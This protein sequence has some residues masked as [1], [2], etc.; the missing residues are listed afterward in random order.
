MRIIDSISRIGRERLSI[1]AF[2]AVMGFVCAA[3]VSSIPDLKAMLQFNDAQLGSLLLSG[4]VGT[5]TSYLFVGFLITRLGSCRTTFIGACG[6]VAA[7]FLLSVGF[8]IKAPAVFWCATLAAMGAFG[9]L[10]NTS[11]NTQGGLAELRAGHSIMSSFHAIWSVTNLSGM[12]FAQIVS[13]IAL[14]VHFRIG[15]I[16]AVACVCVFAGRPGLIPSDARAGESA[17]GKGGWRW[18]DRSLLYL[19]LMAMVFM[20]CEG[21]IYDWVGVFYKDALSAPPERV[22][23]GSC[24]VMGAMTVGRFMTDGLINRYTATRIIHAYSLLVFTGLSIALSSP[25]TGLAGTGLHVVATVGYAVAGF[26]IS[27]LVPIVYAKTARTK[28]MAPGAAVTVVSSLGFL[29]FFFAPPLIG[30]VSNRYGLSV[31]LSIFAFLILLGLF[32]HPDRQDG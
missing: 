19:G 3:W 8:A 2:F 22:L 5:A 17:S 21:S 32:M 15:C 23:W 7:T 10:L 25:Y 30:S 27:G 26:G 16:A 14:P 13:Y 18:P 29:G 24:A 11:A 12:L 9:N 1:S 20:G 28:T 6:Y 4:P 31:A